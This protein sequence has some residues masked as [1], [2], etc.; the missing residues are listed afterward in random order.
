MYM[1][2]PRMRSLLVMIRSSRLLQSELALVTLF[3]LMKVAGYYQREQIAQSWESRK[4]EVEYAK[5]EKITEAFE[6]YQENVFAGVKRISS[7][8]LINRE[9]ARGDSADARMVFRTLIASTPPDLAI[10]I[11]NPGKK[12]F[13]WQGGSG[14]GLDTARLAHPPTSFVIDR[15]LYSYLVVVL[16]IAADSSHQWYAVGRCLLDANFPISNRF[17]NNELF[18]STFT[19][20]ISPDIQFAFDPDTLNAPADAFVR[21]PL[22]GIDGK[23]LGSAYIPAPSV[24]SYTYEAAT[25]LQKGESLG[26]LAAIVLFAVLVGRSLSGLQS[27]KRLGVFTLLLWGVRY[28]LL[29]LDLPGSILTLSIFE[30]SVFASQFG[31]GM[32]RSIGDLFVSALVLLYNVMI[33]ASVARTRSTGDGPRRLRSRSLRIIAAI[34]GSAIAG[35]IVCVIL[36]GFASAIHSAVFDSALLYNDPTFIFP[37]PELAVMLGCLGCIGVSVILVSILLT[38]RALDA[39]SGSLVRGNSFPSF[40]LVA[41]IFA[42]VSVAFGA[43]QSHPLMEQHQRLVILAALLVLSG[44]HRSSES[45]WWSARKMILNLCASVLLTVPILDRTAHELDRLHAELLAIDIARP[46]GHWLSVV[47]NQALDQLANDEAATILS[48]HKTDDIEKLAF[49]QWA[50]SILSREGNNCSIR[51]LNE[52]GVVVSEFA[53]GVTP[54]MNRELQFEIAPTKRYVE[55]EPP[56]VNGDVQWHRGYS[57]IFSADGI[58]RGGVWVEL[59]SGR[60]SILRGEATE[61]LKNYSKE[62]FENHFRKLDFSEFDHDTLTTTT[63]ENLPRGIRLPAEVAGSAEARWVEE[64]IAGQEYETYYFPG[65]AEPASGLMLALSLGGLDLRW[66]IYSYLRYVLFYF[67]ALSAIGIVWILISVAGGYRPALTFRMKLMTSFVIVSSL[68]VFIV[69]YYNRE[70]ALEQADAAITKKLSE[71]TML[72]VAEID[73]LEQASIPVELAKLT[74]SRCTQIADRLDADFNVYD[75]V[76]LQAT[77]RPEIFEAELLDRRLS[78]RAVDAL[79]FGNRNF[80]TEN[81]SIG[82]LPYVVGY[83]PVRA[84]SGA[85]IGV[86]SMPTLFRQSEIDQELTRRNV[87]L[88]GAYSIALLVTVL[89]STVFAK[90]IASPILRL[91]G[92]T[93]RVAGGDFTARIDSDRAVEIGE[94]ERAFNVMTANILRS[95]DEKLKAQR[96]L[97]WKEMAQQVAHEIK[98]PLTPMKLSLQ[99]LQAAYRDGAENFGEIMKQVVRTVLEQI[100]TLS[101]ITSEFSQ[102]ARMPVRSISRCHVHEILRGAMRLYSQHPGV[103]WTTEFSATRDAINADDEEIR[104]AFVNI[105]RNALQAM[106]YKGTIAISTSVRGEFIVVQI[107]DSGPGIAPELRE[108]LF[109]PNFSTKT[110]GMGLGLTIVKKSMED[111]GGSVEIGSLEGKGAVAIIRLPLAGETTHA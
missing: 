105:F 72:I 71:T 101:R 73:R 58:L 10:E 36:R 29:W 42:A 62:E 46:A 83:R 59:A 92:M 63:N 68:P 25:Y 109:T 8:P 84:E 47:V 93:S 88:F 31:F 110:D 7:S 43:A 53:M 87:F 89:V 27:W 33:L 70:Y 82:N 30:P 86:V 81:E 17:I 66:H 102:F 18:S 48:S 22:S 24:E 69:A 65:R 39:I 26:L 23:H 76:T 64:K 20:R 4:S 61:L 5:A 41:V 14:P 45:P 108:K 19:S 91:R 3:L 79:V 28:V 50:K 98:N 9:I 74:D 38:E 51:I 15:P 94:L 55:I 49:T 60:G 104:R 21:A 100:E 34:A 106:E 77:S 96:E 11:Y 13:A 32:A 95:Q 54:Y 16:P 12:L 67:L 78:A 85:L 75:G 99:H 1:P 111:A 90:Q 80:I 37:P 2:F 40:A 97:A 44:I 35:V 57:P 52:N 56:S 107:H 6:A 103:S